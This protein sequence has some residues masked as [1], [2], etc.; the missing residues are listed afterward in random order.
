MNA[1]ADFHERRPLNLT[2][3]LTRQRHNDSR[4]L[5]RQV[6]QI[7]AAEHHALTRGQAP[8]RALEPRVYERVTRLG[9]GAEYVVQCPDNV[10]RFRDWR[11]E[12]DNERG[13]ASVRALDVI[14]P[15]RIAQGVQ[16]RATNPGEE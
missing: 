11:I 8:I 6:R 9:C 7:S 3:A 13:R 10:V 4:G 1:S 16:H 15:D 12:G 5:K 2:H 14:D